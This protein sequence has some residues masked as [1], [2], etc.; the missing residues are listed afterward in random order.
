MGCWSAVGVL[1]VARPTVLLEREAK[2]NP[3]KVDAAVAGVRAPRLG[4][5]GGRVNWCRIFGG[6]RWM[7]GEMGVLWIGNCEGEISEYRT[8]SQRRVRCS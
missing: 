8:R 2:G 6:R 1:T 7:K 4:S 5:H 3:A